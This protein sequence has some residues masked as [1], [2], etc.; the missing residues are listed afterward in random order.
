[1]RRWFVAMVTIA[2]WMLLTAVPAL[3]GGVSTPPKP[4]FYVA[5]SVIV[6]CMAFAVVLC[7]VFGIARRPLGPERGVQRLETLVEQALVDGE[8][9]QQP[10]HVVVGPGLEDHDA[11]LEAP[12]HDR[13]P[14]G[15]A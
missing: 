4:A 3:A 9:R 15:A 2:A 14:V 5:S 13:V 12:S 1:M 7:L 8:R 6:A 10:D 11:L